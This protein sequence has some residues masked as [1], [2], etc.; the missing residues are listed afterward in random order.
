LIIVIAQLRLLFQD[1]ITSKYSY[2]R[3]KEELIRLTLVDVKQEIEDEAIKRRQS[4]QTN[5]SQ[6]ILDSDIPDLIEIEDTSAPPYAPVPSPTQ[7]ASPVEMTVP[8]VET[9]VR[10]TATEIANIQISSP[11]E[12]M[13]G[14]EFV[15]HDESND[16][17]GGVASVT[18]DPMSLDKENIPEPGAVVANPSEEEKSDKIP[19][20]ERQPVNVVSS[21]V[22]D[23]DDV[24]ML[25]FGT[26]FTPPLT[27]PPVP[28]RPPQRRKS[29]WGV[30]K[31]GSQ[32]D[33]TECIT[34]CL[35]QLHAA[36]KPEEEDSTGGQIDLFKRYPPLYVPNNNS[37]SFIS[38]SNKR[39]GIYKLVHQPHQL[40]KRKNCT[41][42]FFQ[43]T[44]IPKSVDPS[45]MPST[46]L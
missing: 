6:S 22:E 45:T 32:Q 33:V 37:D 41:A 15:E 39:S 30:M 28:K 10:A 7:M 36:F 3:P 17:S 14:F 38:V 19:L 9:P 20:Q 26:A 4:L 1:L 16:S 31:Y 24:E 2:I 21:E 35:S 11:P 18:T 13:D 27:P 46:E 23:Q 43:Y 44:L 29:T 12:D 8:E 34:N 40:M 42:V 25:D 5:T